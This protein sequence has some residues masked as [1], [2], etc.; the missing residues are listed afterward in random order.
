[1]AINSVFL[2]KIGT[3][4]S[5]ALLK[6]WL[7]DSII[8]KSI[9]SDIAGIIG[10]KFEDIFKARKANR[11]FDR[12]SEIIADEL[13][14]I[15]K[16]A[17]INN[18]ISEDAS[19]KLAS[20][21]IK[22]FDETAISQEI[23]FDKDL[24][25]LKLT[26]YLIDKNQEIIKPLS[27]FLFSILRKLL[28][29]S[30]N[31]IVEIAATL[32]GFDT[33]LGKEVLE[34]ETTSMN[35]IQQVIEKLPSSR[36]KGGEETD[37]E[38][39]TE[40]CRR[41]A[42]KLD[43]VE[44][45]GISLKQLKPRYN[46]S[47][48]YISLKLSEVHQS[49]TEKGSR[50]EEF[51]PFHRRILIRG[52]AGSG[53]TTLLQWIAVTLTRNEFEG[54]LKLWNE[55]VPFFIRLRSYNNGNFPKPSE[56]V[57]SVARN[58]SDYMPGGW[59]N[60]KLKE[61]KC[62][63]LI[64][65]VDEVA[66]KFRKKAKEWL[67]ELMEEYPDPIYIISSRPTAIEYNWLS[68]YSFTSCFI[69]EL[70]RS[71]VQNF[72]K[73]WHQS[74]KKSML[75]TDINIGSYMKK[76]NET[77]SDVPSVKSLT[78][79]PLLLSMLCALNIDRK[80]HIPRDRMELYRVVLETLLE[81][82]DIERQIEAEVDL[83]RKEKEVLLQDFAY[84]LLL[85]NYTD[86]DFSD[87]LNRVGKQIKNVQR[88]SEY[89]SNDVF[90][91]LLERSGL[92]RQPTIGRINFIHKTFQEYLSAS[93]IIHENSIGV[94]LN[95]CNSD[96]WREVIILAAGH[97]NDSQRSKLIEGLLRKAKGSKQDKKKIEMLALSCIETSTTISSKTMSLLNDTLGELFPPS[98]GRDAKELAAAG[99]SIIE[100]LLNYTN[101]KN[102]T[103]EL[104]IKCLTYL[105][106]ENA[107]FTIK[108]FYSREDAGI[109]D[110]I[111]WAWDYFNQYQYGLHV[112]KYCDIEGPVKLTEMNSLIG[113]EFLD[114]LKYLEI[115]K[116]RLSNI[117]SIRG[118]TSLEEL[119]LHN[120]GCRDLDYLGDLVNLKSLRISICGWVEDFSFLENMIGLQY[121]DL[122]DC[123]N[124]NDISIL[125]NLEELV[126]L[127]IRDCISITDIS[128]LEALP[129][130]EKVELHSLSLIDT[131]DYEASFEIDFR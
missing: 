10:G 55:Y 17:E 46:L 54:N 49:F 121:L 73:H 64:D 67:V 71:D 3:S 12:I 51:L 25:P 27:P 126:Y 88:I 61:K 30:C 36:Y 85:N 69:Q 50:A 86:C 28:L 78:T 118:L 75:K 26:D 124:F 34:R 80:S 94:L 38:F 101:S 89:N 114:D 127:N 68:D 104:C 41:V 5:K 74:C 82:R 87:A 76:L 32:P 9:S 16:N 19:E 123:R 113:I 105:G 117:R 95:K 72:L 92:L 43:Y 97:A 129:K 103:V 8:A 109:T 107:M 47:T 79:S 119:S 37:N 21:I 125:T 60:R 90:N 128:A 7:K 84:W 110:A 98:N 56:F 66:H 52:E 99:D 45:F 29:E 40:Y 53:K 39:E 59:V 120:C 116:S 131:M 11:F 122:G 102:S 83:S 106:T 48:A 65:G 58:V 111:I 93:E 70:T 96:Q 14:L 57:E 23:L 1:M 2:I 31:Y 81:N 6:V 15:F 108:S 20:L 18:R 112:L 13:K 77:I 22:I 44:I 4:V 100:H 24:S 42:L 33:D 63:V 91:Y 62:I 115:T 130:L 35:L